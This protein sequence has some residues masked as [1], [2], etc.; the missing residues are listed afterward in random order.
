MSH[1]TLLSLLPR[2]EN[3]VRIAEQTEN[4]HLARKSS[5][6]GI[7]LDIGDYQSRQSHRKQIIATLGRIE[8][9]DIFVD[10]SFVAHKHC[11]FC[12]NYEKSEIFIGDV[13]PEHSTIVYTEDRVKITPFPGRHFVISDQRRPSLVIGN[14]SSGCAIFDILWHPSPLKEIA[15]WIKDRGDGSPLCGFLLSPERTTSP[16]T[17]KEL[18]TLGSGA[19]G[20]VKKVDVNGRPMAVRI[21]KLPSEHDLKAMRREVGL[22]RRISHRHIVQLF[23]SEGWE[24]KLEI[25]IFMQLKSGGSLH[26]LMYGNGPQ[27]PAEVP[28]YQD[29]LE[30]FL[31]QNLSALDHLA[32]RDPPIIHRDLRPENILFDIKP[33]VKGPN[34]FIFCLANFS[35]ACEEGETGR[36]EE[37]GGSMPFKAP[38]AEEREIKPT[39]KMDIWSLFL[40]MTWIVDVDFQKNAMDVGFL[41]ERINQMHRGINL[42][43]KE[44]WPMARIFPWNRASAA[45]MLARKFKG[46]GA[47]PTLK[48]VGPIRDTDKYDDGDF[49]G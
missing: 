26:S 3:A 24:H 14:L 17:Y 6:H 25:K 9:A 15:T 22:M 27:S 28:N 36:T 12:I 20:S 33:N 5:E 2:N 32:T 16:T 8:D 35:V 11:F 44:Y 18:E 13:S 43:L 45:Q 49:F 31:Q 10:L 23:S 42:G 47:T 41:G 46:E 40:V 39:P 38:E 29:F 7:L 21:V 19:L 30:V 37:F 48:A 1:R 34:K 4:S